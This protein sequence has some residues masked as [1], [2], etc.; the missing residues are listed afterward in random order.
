[1]LDIIDLTIRFTI[2]SIVFCE[3]LTAE[4]NIFYWYR[5]QI[6][7]LPMWLYKPLG[8]CTVC[9]SGQVALWGSLALS[10]G[11]TAISTSVVTM[12]MVDLMT[13][14]FYDAT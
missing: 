4:G 1:M 3:I 12:L 9:Y 6:D 14:T 2:W 11:L 7:K 10:Y 5:L 13:K 8:G